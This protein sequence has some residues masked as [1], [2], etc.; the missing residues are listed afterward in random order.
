MIPTKADLES[1][2]KDYIE[3]A[4]TILGPDS[5]PTQIQTLVLALTIAVT[6][7]T[8]AISFLSRKK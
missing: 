7:Q 2:V 5:A 6:E 4:M 8:F 1:A 3:I